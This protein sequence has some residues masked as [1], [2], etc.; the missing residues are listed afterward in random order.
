MFKPKPRRQP[1]LAG[2]ARATCRASG[3]LLLLGGLWTAA[4]SGA[5]AAEPGPAAENRSPATPE[6]KTEPKTDG[7]ATSLPTANPVGNREST[8]RPVDFV[9]VLRELRSAVHEVSTQRTEA[10]K[11]GDKVREICL[12]ER[13]RG[14]AQALESAEQARVGWESANQASDGTRARTEQ[15]RAQRARELG[16][17]L[18]S[19]AESCGGSTPV[20]AKPTTVTAAGPGPLDD[21]R[22]G[23]S[24]LAKPNPL[25]LELPSRPNPASAF[26]AAR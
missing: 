24:E 19:A 18:R 4:P 25:R 12:Y 11:A 26:R 14:L 5:S 7:Q 22:P 9:A 1:G 10:Q 2:P 6:P 23:P 17:A 13:Q 21:P 16:Q 15:G 3:M 8:D 20:A